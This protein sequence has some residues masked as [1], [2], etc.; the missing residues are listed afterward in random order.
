MQLRPLGNTS[1]S[2]TLFL[3]CHKLTID[4]FQ[5]CLFDNNYTSLIISGHPSHA[6]LVA[7]WDKVYMEYCE[8]SQNGLYNEIFEV[9]KTIEDLNAKINICNNIILYLQYGFDQRL[10][11]ILNSLALRCD[12][13][14]ED[15][16]QILIKKLNGVIGRIKKWFPKLTESEKELERLRNENT[17]K[18]DRGYFDDILEAMSEVK[19]YYIRGEEITV[20]RFCRTFAKMQLDA[21]KAQMK[22]QTNAH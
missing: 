22:A 9:M 2:S 8:L 3:D 13:T 4:K 7:A 18:M 15:E 16:G 1:T 11:D 14:A 20:A 6:E 21:E 19:G 5:D 17:G 10:V 12:V